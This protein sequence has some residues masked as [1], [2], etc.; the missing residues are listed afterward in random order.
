MP[1]ET[2][3][4][5]WASITP[6][7]IVEL[8]ES[9]IQAMVLTVVD[10][11]TKIACFIPCAQLCSAK[12]TV[13]FLFTHVFHLHR[14]PGCITLDQGPHVV[15]CLWHVVFQRLNILIFV[16]SACHLQTDGHFL[17]SITKKTDLSSFPML[18]LHIIVLTMPSRAKPL[19]HQLHPCFHLTLPM[20][21]QNPAAPD[22]VG[23]IHHVQ[24][25]LKGHLKHSKEAFK[26]HTDC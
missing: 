8:H 12:V 20:A 26:Q 4:R 14:L 11:L 2:L 15:S 24:K 9:N 19:L 5:L 3:S 13:D 22:V 16:S 10:Q 23:Q 6:D 25:E 21:S 1:P 7:L 17:A 18:S